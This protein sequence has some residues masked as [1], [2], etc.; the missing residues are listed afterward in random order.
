MPR[1]HIVTP[2]ANE[3]KTE[4]IINKLIRK[5]YSH[6]IKIGCKYKANCLYP[7]I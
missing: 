2:S 1:I 3:K 4:G 5:K 6:A 7:N